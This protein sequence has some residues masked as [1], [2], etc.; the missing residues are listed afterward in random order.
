MSPLIQ[1]NAAAHS[2]TH[3]SLIAPTRGPTQVPSAHHTQSSRAKL[4]CSSAAAWLSPMLLPNTPFRSTAAACSVLCPPAK[5]NVP[6][7]SRLASSERTKL[8]CAACPLGAA[9]SKYPS[10]RS[11]ALDPDQQVLLG[12]VDPD[13]QVRDRII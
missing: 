2:H 3:C 13:Q 9:P 12:V 5:R 1:R 10:R 4:T 11:P 8:I 7:T 6:A